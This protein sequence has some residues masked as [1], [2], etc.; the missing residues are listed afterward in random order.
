MFNLY[1]L[2]FILIIIITAVTSYRRGL[3]LTLL[4]AVSGF[5]SLALVWLVAP[6]LSC[7]FVDLG[8]FDGLRKNIESAIAAQI[9]A[10]G[11]G[12]AKALGG[13]GVP[14][15]WQEAVAA[16]SGAAGSGASAALADSLTRLMTSVATVFIVFILFSIVVRFVVKPLA[17]AV[18]RIPVIGT[19]NRIGGL[20]F[21]L[22]F[23]IF[24][25]CIL[26]VLL[27]ALVPAV[28]S[29]KAGLES[30]ALV[31]WFSAHDLFG[32]VAEKILA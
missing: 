10:A 23:G 12:A 1:D 25:T 4:T 24:L 16:E 31:S 22:L 15:A 13:L 9:G 28:P 6:H 20:L 29:L 8:V 32:L 17:N 2:T 19:V 5:I 14:A 26:V 11:T 18:N 27:N 7:L 30:S 3:L 21:G